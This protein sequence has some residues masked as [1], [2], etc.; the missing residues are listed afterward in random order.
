MLTLLDLLIGLVVFFLMVSVAAS[1]VVEFFAS[2]LNL[3]AKGLERFITQS[4]GEGARIELSQWASAFYA[5]PTIRGLYTPTM[6]LLSQETAPSYIPAATFSSTLLDLLRS[7]GTKRAAGDTLT[8]D[9]IKALLAS[10]KLPTG[11][12]ASLQSTMTRGATELKDIQDDLEKWF[13]ANM[14]RA[15]GWYKRHTQ[16]WLFFFALILAA[17]FNLDTFYLASRLMQDS[18]LATALV[19]TGVAINPGD[20]STKLEDTEAKVRLA[21]SEIRIQPLTA[22]ASTSSLDEKDIRT[23]FSA[24]YLN[25]IDGQRALDMLDQAK[26]NCATLKVEV[27]AYRKEIADDPKRTL[28]PKLD[29]LSWAYL[30][31]VKDG[32]ETARKLLDEYLKERKTSFDKQRAEFQAIQAKLPKMRWIFEVATTWNWQG[33][34]WFLALLGW[35]VTAFMASLGASFWF[36][37]LGRLAN[38][39]SVGSKPLQK[40]SL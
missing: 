3:R 18:E 21:I 19:E 2:Y 17:A 26:A 6:R 34:D 40:E 30:C 29:T 12:A 27:T 25:P 8:I 11:L 22:K 20:G 33:R 36:E 14:Q 32:V 23:L 37:T 31:P 7:A 39:R 16:A 28:D 5:H 35:L 4:F 13:D 38:L 15:S 1:Y 24:N 9:D 10:G